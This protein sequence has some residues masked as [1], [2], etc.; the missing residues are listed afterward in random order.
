MAYIKGNQGYVMLSGRQTTFGTKTTPT[1]TGTIQAGEDLQTVKPQKQAMTDR[2]R[3]RVAPSYVQ[4]GKIH[5]EG[6]LTF[7]LI[8]D[9]A[10]GINLA[11]VLGGANT[12][13]GS[14]TT[15]YTHT[16]SA[17]SACLDY[18][19]SGIT[20]QK[21]LGGC[22]STML[23][24][25]I[26]CFANSFTLTIPEDGVVTYA[27][28]YMGVKNEYGG[29]KATPSYSAKNP[30]E[31]WM[32]HVEVGS[33]IGSTTAIKITEA[34]LSINNNLQMMTDHNASNQYP[35]G[36]VPGSR[37]VEMSITLKQEDSLTM[38]NYFK[39]DTENAVKLVLT[40]PSLA[41]SSSGVYSLT[42]NLPRVTWLGEEPKLDSVDVLTGSYNLTALWSEA[43]GY[44]I[45]A[46][47]VNSQSGV[48]TI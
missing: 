26:S 19:Q 39:D 30:F 44:D 3:N 13:S 29:A 23:V 24:D 46:I 14:S 4:K 7:D 45:Q 12:V 32:A 40:H 22:G 16:F 2:I 10:E 31:G 17:S 15:G 35:S 47:L 20:I 5:V 28:N 33:V 38:Y 25:N 36:F 1:Y 34:T 9:E 37:T 43:S 41:G 11:M 8:P 48:Y 21:F 18:P 27:V 42:F 6:T